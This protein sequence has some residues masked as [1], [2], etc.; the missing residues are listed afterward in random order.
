LI[1]LNGAELRRFVGFNF[2]KLHGYL[3]QTTELHYRDFNYIGD[4]GNQWERFYDS[5][6]RFARSGEADRD[7]FRAFHESKNDHY[8]GVGTNNP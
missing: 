2:E 1:L 7:T 5:Y 6:D 3:N 8:R 4:T